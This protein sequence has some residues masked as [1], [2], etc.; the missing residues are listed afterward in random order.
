MNAGTP[1]NWMQMDRLARERDA[2]GEPAESEREELVPR[3]PLSS[4]PAP[5]RTPLLTTSSSS[6]QGA[7]Q[8]IK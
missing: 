3:P 7:G 8:A 6:D 4:S 5:T 1:A 2:E